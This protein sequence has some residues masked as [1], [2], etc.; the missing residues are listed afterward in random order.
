[1]GLNN[2]E[3][4]Q[5]TIRHILIITAWRSGSTL[6]GDLISRYPGTFYSF[7][8]KLF[9]I[10]EKLKFARTASVIQNE[11]F[12]FVSKVFKCELSSKNII[13]GEI[14]NKQNFH[15]LRKNFRM[16]NV[17]QSMPKTQNDVCLMPDFYSKNC[18]LF[19]IQLIK[20]AMLR[21][22]TALKILHDPVLGKTMKLVILFR[23]P[24]GMMNSRKNLSWCKTHP[25]CYEPKVFCRDMHNDVLAAYNAKKEFPGKC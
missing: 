24:R 13:L 9:S 11:Y 10:E 2:Q 4:Q 14:E 3:G 23:D 12:E 6:L 25:F 19:P 5:N 8:P 20:V 18:P 1:M 15:R 7:E 22:Q 21:V 17:C 16:W